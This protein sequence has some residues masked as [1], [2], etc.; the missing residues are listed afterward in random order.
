MPRS[1][2]DKDR[3]SQCQHLQHDRGDSDIAEFPAVADDLR[4]EPAKAKRAALVSEGKGAAQ[5]QEF[6]VPVL[7]ECHVRGLSRITFRTSSARLRAC[8]RS[9]THER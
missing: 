7:A 9:I 8:I 3:Q 5:Q 6:A 4:D 1:D 2:L